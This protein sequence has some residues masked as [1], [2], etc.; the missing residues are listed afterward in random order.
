MQHRTEFFKA[1]F[2]KQ[3]LKS[4]KFNEAKKMGLPADAVAGIKPCQDH[5]QY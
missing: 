4:K 3:N 5:S 2:R 1:F